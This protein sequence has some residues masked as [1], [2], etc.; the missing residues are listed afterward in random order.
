MSM[1]ETVEIRLPTYQRPALLQNAIESVRKQTYPHWRVVVLDDCP[2]QSARELVTS[3]GDA[4]VHYHHNSAQLRVCGN[5]SLAFSNQSLNGQEPSY[6]AVLEDDNLWEPDYLGDS[7]LRLRESPTPAIVRNY[8]IHDHYN[9]GR[10]VYRD[11]YPMQKLYGDQD[12]LLSWED[13][14]NQALHDFGIGNFAWFWRFRGGLDLSLSRIRENP[15]AQE[16]CRAV[17]SAEPI[18]YVAKV[19]SSFGRFPERIVRPEKTPQN[20]FR[21]RMGS[22]EQLHFSRE[23]VRMMKQRHLPLNATARN[24]LA[25]ARVD[26]DVVIDWAASGVAPALAHLKMPKDWLLLFR[27]LLNFHRMGRSIAKPSFQSQC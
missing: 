23:L 11:E 3:L 9:D 22:Y 13:R 27:R 14:A 8:R 5:L 16:R 19:L 24:L 21:S 1:I 26:N 7:I 6:V 17:C 20:V 25:E 15:H 2:Q 10:L 18:L 4:R 12:R